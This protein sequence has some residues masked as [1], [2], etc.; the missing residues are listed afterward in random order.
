MFTK[1]RYVV[2]GWMVMMSLSST[3][4]GQ[5][6]PVSEPEALATDAESEIEG[7]RRWFV[8]M[9]IGGYMSYGGWRRDVLPAERRLSVPQPTIGLS[10]GYLWYSGVGFEVSSA[11]RGV[12]GWN[13]SAVRRA[14]EAGDQDASLLPEDFMWAQTSFVMQVGWRVQPRLVLLLSGEAGV[15]WLTPDPFVP[16]Q[17]GS[18]TSPAL[19]L[20]VSAGVGIEY[21]TWLPGVAVGVNAGWR[22]AVA[23][24]Q[25]IPGVSITVPLKYNF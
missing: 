16:V 17:D 20:A 22:A 19:G 11:I 24:S 14:P 8:G 6:S 12:I 21:R 23:S 7:S 13:E 9:D 2:L 10:A 25:V 15:A 18:S 5:L 3:A 4:S 1:G